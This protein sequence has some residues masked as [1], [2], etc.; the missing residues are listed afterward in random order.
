MTILVILW[1][2]N[3]FHVPNFMLQVSA[4]WSVSHVPGAGGSKK[5]S[6]IRVSGFEEKAKQ[7]DGTVGWKLQYIKCLIKLTDISIFLR[8]HYSL[9][10]QIC[11]LLFHSDPTVFEITPS[12][13]SLDGPTVSVTAAIACPPKDVNRRS[14]YPRNICISIAVKMSS[15][16]SHFFALILFAISFSSKLSYKLQWE[17]ISCTTEV[18]WIVLGLQYAHAARC[19]GEETQRPARFRRRC[20][21]SAPNSGEICAG[22]KRE[23]QQ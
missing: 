15:F 11:V 5:I 21:V 16:K 3:V 7:I 23:V 12:E 4:K 8:V 13:G 20:R 14:A 9:S 22:E 18:D 17:W 6:S 2:D 19:S 10:Y 1:L